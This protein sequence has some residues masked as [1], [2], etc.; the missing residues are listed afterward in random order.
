MAV[1]QV[2]KR[3]VLNEALLPE[4]LNQLVAAIAASANAITDE[5]VPAT[6]AWNGLKLGNAPDGA[7]VP[8]AKFND[9]AV[10]LAKLAVGALV[11]AVADNTTTPG[12]IPLATLTDI[13]EVV[14]FTRGG[15]VLV[16]Y[17]ASGMVNKAIA[18]PDA[19]IIN[20]SNNAGLVREHEQDMTTGIGGAA[21]WSVAGVFVEQ[22]AASTRLYTLR[23]I[24]SGSGADIFR[25]ESAYLVAM[26]LA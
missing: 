20:L 12:G 10:T 5:Q 23:A 13:A 25:V 16:W 4:Q 21:P 18:G 8:T 2:P 9:L 19:V 3:W 17:G 15:R 26:E 14:V 11:P 6:A 22:P 1:F 24:F 7:G